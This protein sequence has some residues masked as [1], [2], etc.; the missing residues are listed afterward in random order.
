MAEQATAQEL[1]RLGNKIKNFRE[2]YAR[3][4]SNAYGAAIARTNDSALM[5][6]YG[7]T[8]ARAEKTD[9]Y[10]RTFENIIGQTGREWLGLGAFP[11][12]AAA[13]VAG[14]IAVITGTI[15]TINGFMEKVDVRRVQQEN[16][17]MSYDEALR[18][19]EQ[20]KQGVVGRT[21]DTVNLALFLGGG[22]LLYKFLRG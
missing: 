2:Q 7:E 16:P 10:I 11:I 14:L 6:E 21:L 20:S 1:S 9:G 3:L 18:I 12:I 5:L 8:L 4:R 17:G 19:V 15:V 13:T 22:W